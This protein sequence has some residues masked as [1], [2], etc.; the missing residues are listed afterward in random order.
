MKRVLAQGSEL[1]RFIVCVNRVFTGFI[2]VECNGDT[3]ETLNGEPCFV[4]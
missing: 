4:Y 3:S 2:T 1:V